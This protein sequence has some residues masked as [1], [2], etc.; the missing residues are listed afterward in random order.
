MSLVEALQYEVIYYARLGVD[1]HSMQGTQAIEAEI[2]A[3][4]GG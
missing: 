2:D 3:I 4:L 1:C